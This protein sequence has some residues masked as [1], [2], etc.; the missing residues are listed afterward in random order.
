[1]DR[2][3]HFY[4]FPVLQDSHQ[5]GNQVEMDLVHMVQ[6]QE[7]LQ[8]SH[9]VRKQVKMDLVHMAQD[10]ESL[11]NYQHVGNQV[12]MNLHCNHLVVLVVVMVDHCRLCKCHQYRIQVYSHFHKMALSHTNPMNCKQYQLGNKCQYHRSY[13]YLVFQLHQMSIESKCKSLTFDGMSV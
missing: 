10:Q 3:D 12:Q 4:L 11:Q 5:V 2:N 9:Q 6:D 8:D 1:M 7:P 13:Q